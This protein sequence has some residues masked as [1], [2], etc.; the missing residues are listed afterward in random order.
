MSAYY[1][2]DQVAEQLGVHVRT[3]RNFVR[4]GRLAA[5]RVGKQYRIAAE[6]LAKLTG[7]PATAF[8]PDGMHRHI[9]VSS[10]VEVD[11]IDPDTVSRLTAMLM[12]AAGSRDGSGPPLRVQTSYDESRARL[13][14]VLM[15]AID[16]TTAMLKAVKALAEP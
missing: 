7:R 10:I 11:A 9:E 6:D 12:G 5:S 13:K 16:D 1:S 8:Q 14:V 3:V 4:D 15:G 2:I